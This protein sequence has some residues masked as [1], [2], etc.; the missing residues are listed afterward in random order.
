MIELEIPPSNYALRARPFFIFTLLLV[1][2][3]VVGKFIISDPWGAISMLFIV[4]MGALSLTG[5][6]GLSASN[7]LFYAVMAMISA[8]FDIISCVTYFKNS[9]YQPFEKGMPTMVLAAQ[10]IFIASPIVLFI[11]GF[12]AYSI[13]SDCQRQLEEMMPVLESSGGGYGYG[14]DGP[15][16]QRQQNYGPAPR[17]MAGNS[18]QSRLVGG[19]D[20]PQSF[21]G[22]GH[23]LGP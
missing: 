6:Y 1:S 11:S 9:K 15:R 14:Y 8:V 18:R 19:N 10:I 5:E 17:G 12:L 7:M 13:F 21:Q 23:T 16:Q 22:R 4:L 3:L 20:R 2:A